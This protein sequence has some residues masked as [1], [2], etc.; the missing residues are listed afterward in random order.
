MLRSDRIVS[1]CRERT[2][3]TSRPGEMQVT[4]QNLKPDTKYS[5]RVVA[6]NKH[7]R[8][9]SSVALKV[10]TQ[11]EGRSLNT[12]SQRFAFSMRGSFQHG[13][14]ENSPCRR[15]NW[16]YQH[17]FLQGCFFPVLFSPKHLVNIAKITLCR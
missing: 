8:G 15:R 9:E 4:I 13:L 5:F 6:Y 12:K 16:V 2:V 14:L 10:A 17:M 7:G 11:P 1:F 3:N